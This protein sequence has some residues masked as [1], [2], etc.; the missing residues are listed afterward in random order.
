MVITWITNRLCDLYVDWFV[1]HNLGT[2]RERAF[3]WM[4]RFLMDIEFNFLR[5][6]PYKTL[7][8]IYDL[9]SDEELVEF[10]KAIS[11]AL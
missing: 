4:I 2:F 9:L 7:V 5:G 1:L 8:T 10:K 6:R 3:D 11:N